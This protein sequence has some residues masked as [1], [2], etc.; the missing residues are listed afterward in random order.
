VAL[1]LDLERAS[2]ALGE[3]LNGYLLSRV[4][5]VLKGDFGGVATLFLLEWAESHGIVCIGVR[6]R[7]GP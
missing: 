1:G 7:A 4:Y 6:S 5:V 2:L 3:I